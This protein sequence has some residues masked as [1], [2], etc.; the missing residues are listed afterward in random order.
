MWAHVIATA[1]L[2]G[3]PGSGGHYGVLEGGGAVDYVTATELG[4][5]EDDAV[6]YD[7]DGVIF[8]GSLTTTDP[9]A[10]NVNGPDCYA[11]DGTCTAANTIISGGSDTKQ[12]TS[13]NATN[14]GAGDTVVVTCD[15][16]ATTLTEGTDF[17]CDG[18]DA[19][20]ATAIAAVAPACAPATAVTTTVGFQPAAT[21]HAV[22]I[23]ATGG[24][25]CGTASNGTDGMVVLS[26]KAL[27]NDVLFDSTFDGTLCLGDDTDACLTSLGGSTLFFFFSAY[28]ASPVLWTSAGAEYQNDIKLGLGST[29]GGF[30]PYTWF[31]GNSTSA[32]WYSTDVDGG[33]TDG[34]LFTNTQGTDA[35]V[36]VGD[37]H[38]QAAEYK[39]HVV[40]DC[41]DDPYT[42]PA[43]VHY[44][45]VETGTGSCTGDMNITLPAVACTP[46]TAQDTCRRLHI[47]RIGAIAV[48]IGG[49]SGTE[50]INGATPYSLGSDYA[51]ATL[52]ETNSAST[53][54]IVE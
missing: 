43:G 17:D 51:S 31:I 5:C 32:G 14:C 24:S 30:N 19:E 8:C 45:T 21:T 49:D 52:I 4:T 15:G 27:V 6:L 28:G 42:V 13:V 44:I 38:S 40:I 12:L 39:A 35:I 36:V 41:D 54:W 47:T 26:G 50:T 33:G 11:H 29:G 18:T 23:A 1:L 37:L 10:G 2:A 7:T 34:A 9:S 53:D 3:S 25:P 16:A 48:A 22:T 20:C 46:A